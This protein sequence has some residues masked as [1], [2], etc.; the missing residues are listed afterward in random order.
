[1]LSMNNILRPT[2]KRS[3]VRPLSNLVFFAIVL[4]FFSFLNCQAKDESPITVQVSPK[5]PKAGETI[6]VKV[7]SLPGKTKSPKIFFD[8]SKIPVF[9]LSENWYRGLVPISANHEPGKYK[10]D[11]F[12]GGKAEHVD[13]VIGETE[14]PIESITLSKQVSGLRASKIEKNLVAKALNTISGKKFWTGKFI[15]PS[16]ARKSA[17]YGVRRKIN[18][19]FAPGNFHKG[20]DFAAS[21]GDIVKA[22]ED[23]KVVLVG[24]TSKGFVVNGNCVFLDHGHGV[25]SAYLHLSSVLVKEGEL[26]K[27]GQKIGKVGSTGIATGP[28]LHWGMYVLGKTVEPLVWTKRAVD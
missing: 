28:H 12:Y 13:L 9:R 19:N 18:G 24:L 2:L 26:V 15:L 6:S 5:N 14:Y 8:K 16:N 4:I 3:N 11:V 20:L 22:P 25:V 1:M 17:V 27:K 7:R 23:G 10:L 21:E